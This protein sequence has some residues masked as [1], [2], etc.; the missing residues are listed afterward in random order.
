MK[1]FFKNFSLFSLIMIAAFSLQA[2]SADIPT[3]ISKD[4][5]E[6]LNVQKRIVKNRD[7]L[8]SAVE[9]RTKTINRRDKLVI[10]AQEA[11]AA[12]HKQAGNFSENF[13]D[14]K[15]AKQA[16]K[17]AKKAASKAKSLAKAEKSIITLENRINNLQKKIEKDEAEM[18]QL[19]AVLGVN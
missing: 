2:Q 13:Q 12:N 14:K 3:T 15:Q 10:E 4:Q 1:Q 17:S 5:K 16:A 19:K 18:A 6:L 9:N 7:K 11:S 8:F